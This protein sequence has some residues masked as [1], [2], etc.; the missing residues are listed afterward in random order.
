MVGDAFRS[1]QL[2]EAGANL[3]S[4]VHDSPGQVHQL[5]SDLADGSFSLNV[6][7][8]ES[9]ATTRA[10]H[11]AR[12]RLLVAA[13]CAVGLS[14]IVSAPGLPHPGGV[15]IAWP[16]GAAL[17]VLYAWIFIAWRRLK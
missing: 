5:L 7:A 10:R 3:V 13:V 9:R 8:T 14:V 1:E 16:L 6:S 2:E 12:A 4:L 11:D 15:S 17:A